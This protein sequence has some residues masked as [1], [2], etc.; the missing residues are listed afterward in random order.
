M[1]EMKEWNV[2]FSVKAGKQYQKLKRSGSRPSINDII[3][4]LVLDLQRRG[5]HLPDWP[6]YSSLEEECF[7]CHLHRGKPT[8]V[9]CWRIIDK[10]IK[11]IEVYYVGTHEGAPY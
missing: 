1:R 11:Q 3:D 4:L 6:H 5:P 8:F 2:D 7:H 10:K 9:A